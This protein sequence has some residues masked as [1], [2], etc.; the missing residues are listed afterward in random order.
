MFEKGYINNIKKYEQDLYENQAWYDKLGN[1]VSKLVGLTATNVG[2]GLVGTLYGA[3]K[4]LVTWDSS[5]LFDNEV[6]TAT[7]A[8]TDYL[9][10]RF[11]V[12]G[13]LDYYKVRQEGGHVGQRF[14]SNPWKVIND[15]I[16]SAISFVGGVVMTE[17]AATALAPVTG[18][19]S[20]V[21]G[22]SRN[23]AMATRYFSN[24]V[25]TLRGLKPLSDFQK[26]KQLLSLT[27]NYR[28]LLGTTRGI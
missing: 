8:A 2:G 19:T 18:G 26:A 15:D 7:D 28:K 21:A 11:V 14:L 9:N 6:F 25:K 23:A 12:H 1:S 27:E 10:K 22:T 5:A 16:S 17:M 13:G 24:S 20:L 3:G 4:A